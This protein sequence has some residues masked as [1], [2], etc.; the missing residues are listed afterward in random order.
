MQA[1]KDQLAAALGGQP[2]CDRPSVAEVFRPA[3]VF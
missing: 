2:W 3:P 1:A